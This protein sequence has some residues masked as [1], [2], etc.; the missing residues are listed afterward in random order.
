L[1]T[2]LAAT[3][4]APDYF[5]LF[6]LEANFSLDGALLA[7]RY[8]ELQRRYHPDRFAGK[9][10]QEVRLAVHMASLVNQGYEIL[11]TPVKRA[12]YL[13]ERAGIEV[14][15]QVTADGQFLLAQMTLRE[16]LAEVAASADPFAALEALAA[17]ARASF[18]S[19]EQD[20]TAALAAGEYPKAVEAV[21][22]MQFFAKFLADIDAMEEHLEN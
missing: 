19:L 11:K 10:A 12:L 6:G 13:L 17:T 1:A 14:G 16:E 2:N 15:H 7:E 8:R 18:A 20:F 4:A 3:N 9:A 5:A 21:A 22:K